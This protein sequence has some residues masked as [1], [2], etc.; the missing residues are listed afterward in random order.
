MEA[1]SN[2]EITRNNSGQRSSLRRSGHG[3]S[4]ENKILSFSKDI[5][6]SQPENISI[7][8]Q[9]DSSE[10]LSINSLHVDI[11]SKEDRSDEGSIGWEWNQEKARPWDPWEDGDFKPPKVE[12][13]NEVNF[14][15]G[16]GPNLGHPRSTVFIQRPTTVQKIYNMRTRNQPVFTFCEDPRKANNVVPKKE[17]I[18]YRNIARIRKTVERVRLAQNVETPPPSDFSEDPTEVSKFVFC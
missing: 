12:L 1:G 9:N 14:M 8:S 5:I 18:D 15:G 16:L 3:H 2:E 17:K 6:F 11:A 7:D 10:N 13:P 4:F